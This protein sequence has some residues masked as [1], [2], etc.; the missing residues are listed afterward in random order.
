MNTTTAPHTL[1]FPVDNPLMKHQVE[2]YFY[3]CSVRRC[4]EERFH[5]RMMLPHG[6]KTVDLSAAPPTLE[7]PSTL[8]VFQ[9][10][11]SPDATIQVHAIQLAREMSPADALAFYH[12]AVG[13]TVVEERTLDTPGGAVVDVLTRCETVQGPRISRWL[14][15]KDYDCLFVLQACCPENEYR[16]Q[17][18]AFFVALTSCQLLQ[19]VGWPLVEN[20][21]SFSRRHPGDFCLFYP[22]SWTLTVEAGSNEQVLGVRLMNQVGDAVLGEMA[23][24]TLDRDAEDRPQA[25]VDAYLDGLRHAG[26]PVSPVS[27]TPCASIGGFLKTW[28]GQAQISQ[29]DGAMEVHVR[30]GKRPD[31]W[32]MLVLFTPSRDTNILAWA[33]NTR[34]FDI[35]LD[36]FRTPTA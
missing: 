33:M 13:E 24:T 2:Q 5:F 34:A 6:W 3:A 14:T 18:L 28:Q 21:R 26:M 20:L 11:G 35:L 36:H 23:V 1:P 10:A 15:I 8:V 9:S 19:P 32:F 12:S 30:I 17:A 22:E 7:A 31:A 29:S 27:L 16:R 4:A 25:L